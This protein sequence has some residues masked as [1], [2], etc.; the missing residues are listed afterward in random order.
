MTVALF[1][2]YLTTFFGILAGVPALVA[3]SG[4]SLTPKWQHILSIVGGIGVLGLGAV[5]KAFNVHS[6]ADQVQQST[7]QVNGQKVS[8]GQQGFQGS[9]GIKP[10]N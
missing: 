1:K 2:N 6:T 7:M 9:G 4:I 3:G 5:A 10:S 8:T